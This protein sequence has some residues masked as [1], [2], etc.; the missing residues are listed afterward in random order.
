MAIAMRP[1]L[2]RF[3]LL[4]ALVLTG[5]TVWA[6]IV[7]DFNLDQ[8]TVSGSGGSSGAGN[9]GIVVSHVDTSTLGTSSGGSFSVLGGYVQTLN[10]G[11][12]DSDSVVDASD[13]CPV[14]GNAGQ[15]NLDGDAYGDVCDDNVDGDGLLND[16]DP[17]DDNDGMDDTFEIANRLNPYNPGDAGQDPDNDG[18]TSLEEFNINPLLDP[19]HPDSDGDGI[20]DRLDNAPISWNNDCTSPGPQAMFTDQINTVVMCGA[21]ESITVASPAEVQSAGYLQLIAPTVIF[22][23]GV[24]VTGKMSV[25]SS[26]PC[27]ACLP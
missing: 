1:G 9:Y 2:L 15:E 11:D 12:R 7:E 20:D 4:P 24:S 26:L 25:L 27:A 17:D 10:R 22:N 21:D 23:P 8:S 13:N 18:L 3:I 14:N 16:V 5:T 19:N 6:G